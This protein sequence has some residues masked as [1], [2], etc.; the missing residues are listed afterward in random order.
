MHRFHVD[1]PLA[2]GAVVRMPEPQAR[3]ITRVLRMRAGDEVVVFNGRGGEYL[4]R[5]AVTGTPAPGVDIEL[6]EFNP[7]EA[8]LPFRVT[9][10]QGI[11]SH[12]KMSWTIE[13]AVELG[14]SRIVPLT[15]RR[16]V[17]RLE[18]KNSAA[19]I[20]RFQAIAQAASEQCGRNRVATVSPV[21]LFQ[22]GFPDSPHDAVKLLL[23]PG[24]AKAISAN[25]VPAR[26][27]EIILFAGPEGGFAPE[28]TA[29]ALARGFEPVSLGPRILRTETAG[30]AALAMLAALW[31]G[32]E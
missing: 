16:S 3:H 7:R 27:S 22:Q 29:L 31:G 9:L 30:A 14:V 8:E 28:E 1:L 11:S 17:V 12:D 19:K 10:W 15:M 20:N 24:A 32:L 6:L 4:A 25:P 13:K 23:A 18:G 2:T 5:L 26:G 21:H